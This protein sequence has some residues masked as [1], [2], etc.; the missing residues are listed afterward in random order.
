MCTGRGGGRQEN[1]PL[2][3]KTKI[4]IWVLKNLTVPS[5]RIEGKIPT[6]VAAWKPPLA[7]LP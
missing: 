3:T 7:S 5:L 2:K 1:G 6:D 4:Q